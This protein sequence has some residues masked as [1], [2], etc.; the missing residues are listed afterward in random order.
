MSG[1]LRWAVTGLA[2]VVLIAAGA[3]IAQDAVHR[4][5]GEP[6]LWTTGSSGVLWLVGAALIAASALTRGAERSVLLALLA[7]AWLAPMFSWWSEGAE[8]LVVAVAPAVATLALP[9]LWH[10]L[11]EATAARSAARTVAV[12]TVWIGTAG[13][14][15]LLVLVR[16]PFLDARCRGVCS[17]NPALIIAVPQLVTSAHLALAILAVVVGLASTAWSV[18]FLIRRRLWLPLTPAPALLVI[19][20]TPI[21]AAIAPAEGASP[22]PSAEAFLAACLALVAVTALWTS[23]AALGRRAALRRLA[24]DLAAGTDSRAGDLRARLAEV[25]HDPSVDVLY[26]LEDGRW[27]D[28]TGTARPLPESAGVT[29]VRRQGVTVAKVVGRADGLRDLETIGAA[30]SLAIDNE[31]LRAGISARLAELRASRLHVVEAGDD[32]RRRIERNLH[33]GMQQSLLV[34]QYE[35]AL[36]ASQDETPTGRQSSLGSEAKPTASPSASARSHAA[37]FRQRSTTS[38]SQR[39]CSGSP[40]TPC[41]RSSCRVTSS[42]ARR[43]LSSGRSTSS[44]TRPWR[45]ASRHREP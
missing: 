13:A 29:S 16:D 17:P 35:L 45:V 33:D 21:A 26:P 32:E 14:A 18:G 19:A 28:A 1:V 39:R 15:A 6:T 20:L 3:L 41:S 43:D 37:S 27:V 9:A 7:I 25:L 44:L 10:L 23:I 11:L 8:P 30:A 31:R 5:I 22:L 24:E 40:T 34:L 42:P 12:A 36:A 38:V 2:A 4:G